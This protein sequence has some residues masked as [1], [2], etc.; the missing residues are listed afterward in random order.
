VTTATDIP[1]RALRDPVWYY[2]EILG[3]TYIYDK[4][5]EILEALTQYD[6]VAVLGCNGSGKD[7]RRGEPSS[8]G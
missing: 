6:K 5:R 3:V 2:E 4:Q 7:G 1:R 8:G